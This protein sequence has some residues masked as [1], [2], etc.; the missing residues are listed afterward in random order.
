MKSALNAMFGLILF[1]NVG[2]ADA[3]ICKPQC[4]DYVNTELR[5]K[6]HVGSAINWWN[7]PPGGYTKRGNGDD[8]EPKKGDIVVWANVGG[9]NGHVAIVVRTSSSKVT[10]RDANWSKDWQTDC[11]VRT[12]DLSLSRTGKKGDYR[13]KIQ[14]PNVKGWLH[15]K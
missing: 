7:Q 5:L 14:D 12:R 4:T 3:A 2:H 6:H 15:K 11:N 1:A 13:Y 9:G 8:D 10:V